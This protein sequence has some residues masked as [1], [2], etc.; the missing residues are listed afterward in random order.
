MRDLPPLNGLRA[1]ESVARTG[2]VKAA[3]EEMRVTA[4]AVSHQLRQI[5]EHFGLTLFVRQGRG[6]ALTAAGATYFERVTAHFEGLRQASGQLHGSAG[7]SVLRLRSYTTFATR[8][9]IPRLTQL[10]LAHPEIDVRLTTVSEWSDL[11]DFDAGIRL[12]DGNWPHY[13]C[14]RL[15]SNVLVPVCHPSLIRPSRPADAAWLAEQ[16]ILLVRAR[17]D[18]WGLWCKAAEIDLG[19]LPHRRELE[20]SALAYQAAIEGQGVALAQRVLVS[21]ELANGSLVVP[22][23]VEVDQEDVTY[24]LVSDRAGRKERLVAQLRT[25]LTS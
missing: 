9:L 19:R 25:F 5:E 17:P 22:L 24:Y 6:L 15:V 10:Q 3:A 13:R 20:S 2:S 11:G 14:T 4:G 7:R 1:F 12:G 18:D 23:P 8:W 16:T 21:T